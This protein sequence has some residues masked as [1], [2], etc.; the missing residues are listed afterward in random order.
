MQKDESLMVK[1]VCHSE[2][3]E[4]TFWPNEDIPNEFWFSIWHQGFKRPFCWREKIRWCLNILR[5]GNPW[6]DHIIVSPEQAKMVAEFLNK[7]LDPYG[8]KK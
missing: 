4:V 6:A 7:H 8:K 3:M 2:A 5:T 1:C